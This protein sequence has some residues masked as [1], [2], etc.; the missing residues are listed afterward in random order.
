MKRDER[1][2]MLEETFT[3][4]FDAIKNIVDNPKRPIKFMYVQAVYKDPIEF[5]KEGIEI[6]LP[7]WDKEENIDRSSQKNKQI[8]EG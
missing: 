4:A 6:E 3:K 8:S 1:R 7:D 5:P 2:R